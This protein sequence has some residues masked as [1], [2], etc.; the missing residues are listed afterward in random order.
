MS[1]RTKFTR[2]LAATALSGAVIAGGATAALAAVSHVDGGTWYHGVND[3]NVYSN[4]YHAGAKHAS[5][6]QGKFKADSG[7]VTPGKTSYASAPKRW[8]AKD[9]AYYRFC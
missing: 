3:K 9:T 7:C 4:Y 1:I 5:S 6:V 2:S 8:Y